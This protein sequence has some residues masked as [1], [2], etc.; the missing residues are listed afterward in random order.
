MK[1][2]KLAKVYDD[3]VAKI[4][5]DAAAIQGGN[6]RH[7]DLQPPPNP[8]AEEKFLFTMKVTDAWRAAAQHGT[9]AARQVG[10]KFHFGNS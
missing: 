1:Y 4:N 10:R 6:D 3:V 9:G 2:A 8:N 5:A 7:A